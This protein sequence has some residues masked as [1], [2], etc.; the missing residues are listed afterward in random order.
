LGID[1]ARVGE[2]VLRHTNRVT[3]VGFSPDG[4]RVPTASRDGT[5]RLWDAVR[6]E[7]VILASEHQGRPSFSRDGKRVLTTR[8]PNAIQLR[9]AATGEPLGRPWEHPASVH[10]AEMSPDGKLV[11]TATENGSV[12]LWNPDTGK[13]LGPPIPIHATFASFSPDGRR[14]ATIGGPV[15]PGIWAAV[16]G[17][18]GM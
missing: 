1:P 17:R 12:Q 7:E 11:V 13:A 9:D 10:H 3:W 8:G 15:Q 6:G 5:V 16:Q 2:P 18:S 4:Q 14:L